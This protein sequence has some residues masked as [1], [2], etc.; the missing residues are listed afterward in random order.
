MSRN[1]HVNLVLK[2]TISYKISI[3]IASA[4]GG[5]KPPPYVIIVIAY[6]AKQSFTS[7]LGFLTRCFILRIPIFLSSFRNYVT[8]VPQMVVVVS[9]HNFVGADAYIAPYDQSLCGL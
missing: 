3:S 5:S 6:T 9:P 2:G 4:G 8:K 1:I 7:K